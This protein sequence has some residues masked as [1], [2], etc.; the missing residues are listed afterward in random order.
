[1]CAFN[2]DRLLENNESSYYELYIDEALAMMP[3]ILKGLNSGH[4]IL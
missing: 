2:H 3:L 1:M 4:V